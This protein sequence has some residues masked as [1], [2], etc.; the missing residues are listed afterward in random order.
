[1]ERSGVVIPGFHSCPL[2]GTSFFF[3]VMNF[4]L[5]LNELPFTA[6]IY[7]VARV[8]DQTY[9]VLNVVNCIR[10]CQ[11]IVYSSAPLRAI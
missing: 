5:N 9:T 11:V 2:I 10:H 8:C 4:V 6:S 1:M 7:L 3:E